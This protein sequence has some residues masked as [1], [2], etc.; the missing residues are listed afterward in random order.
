MASEET[1]KADIFQALKNVQQ[2][3]PSF[4]G[5]DYDA[6]IL[7]RNR[8][9]Q[10]SLP[11]NYPYLKYIDEAPLA[12]EEVFDVEQAVEEPEIEHAQQQGI[13]ATEETEEAANERS[14]TNKALII[15]EENMMQVDL[16][17]M[18]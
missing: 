12:E 3:Y 17:E 13:A 6:F 2:K 11:S 18:E 16:E 8:L 4:V 7:N 10:L 9:S 1:V 14:V 5:G 15:G